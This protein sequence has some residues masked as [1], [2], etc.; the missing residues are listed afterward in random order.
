MTQWKGKHVSVLCSAIYAMKTTY[1]TFLDTSCC[2]IAFNKK[3]L[4]QFSYSFYQPEFSDSGK[5][6]KTRA[7]PGTSCVIVSGELHNMWWRSGNI[8]HDLFFCSL[9]HT[10]ANRYRSC[11]PLL[12]CFL[13]TALINIIHL[14]LKQLR[15]VVAVCTGNSVES[16][17]GC[18]TPQ[19][20]APDQ[21]L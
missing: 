9:R 5:K 19:R 1:P 11:A 10:L 21:T 20:T 3:V 16:W 12:L 8:H 14:V 2:D 18:Q 17:R 7:D 6:K 4:H 15:T 13:H